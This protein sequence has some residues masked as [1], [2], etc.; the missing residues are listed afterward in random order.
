[1]AMDVIQ[2]ASHEAIISVSGSHD[3]PFPDFS[4]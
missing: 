2:A 1:M 4:P 3:E